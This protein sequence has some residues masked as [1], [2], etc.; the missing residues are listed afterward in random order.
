MIGRGGLMDFKINV[1]KT[2]KINGKEYHSVEEMPE[3]VR[4]AYEKAMGGLRSAVG[5][6]IVFNGKEYHSVEEMPEDARQAYE[7][8][9]AGA[10]V[11][12]RNKIIFNGQEYDSIEAMPPDAR[13]MYESIMNA[14]KGGALPDISG[15]GKS[16]HVTI[17]GNVSKESGFDGVRRS[18]EPEQSSSHRWG[19][20]VVML[21]IAVLIYFLF[22]HR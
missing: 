12:V 18:A 4:K 10:R 1:K 14:A 11:I 22:V 8:A 15:F 21:L 20:L 2:F 6:K 19:L 9:M 3:D 13:Q 16:S 7:K 17:Q 5:N